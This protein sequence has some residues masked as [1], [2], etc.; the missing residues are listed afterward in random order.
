METRIVEDAAAALVAA[1]PD[2]WRVIA[3][4]EHAEPHFDATL[5]VVSPSGWKSVL[6]AEIH[7]STRDSARGVVARVARW[8]PAAPGT[9]VVLAD[10]ASPVL[11]SLCEEGGINYIDATGWVYLRDDSA[12][13]F[14]R[15]QGA[16]KPPGKTGRRDS[17]MTKLD[18]P[19]ASHVIRALWSARLPAGVRDLAKQA[20]VS[21]GTVSKVLPALVSYGAIVR[22]QS[23]SVVEVDRRR[24]IERWTLDYN[25]YNTNSDFVLGLSPRGADHALK[26]IAE[27]VASGGDNGAGTVVFTGYLAATFY[28]P[29]GTAPV[30]P[31]AQLACY[32]DDPQR[33]AA[34]LK[35]RPAKP[36]TANVLIVRPR[37]PSLL[38]APSAVVELPQ[39]IA[40]LATMGGRWEE[41]AQQ[42]LETSQLQRS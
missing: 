13:L 24:L 3:R 10:Y 17:M 35:L 2:S 33:L 40:D 9:P 31:H 38:Q 26:R 28:L 5:T 29:E 22:D 36:A 14:V 16:E 18:G 20:K 19:G 25:I 12:G 32:V 41:L 11:R 8:R 6:P 7:R 37:D 30:V 4:A 34:D 23:S 42:L 39:A 27:L 21:P 15:N 1:L